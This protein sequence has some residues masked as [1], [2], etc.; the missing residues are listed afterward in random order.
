MGFLKDQGVSRR[1]FLKIPTPGDFLVPFAS[2]QKELAAAAAK[3]LFGFLGGCSACGRATFQRRKVAKVLRA[4]GPGPKGVALFRRQS[5][6]ARKPLERCLNSITAA[7]LNEPGHL[8]L[9]DDLRLSGSTYT[10]GSGRRAATRCASLRKMRNAPAG[11]LCRSGTP[12]TPGGN[13]LFVAHF[14]TN[15][16]NYG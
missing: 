13:P 9:Q 5:R 8:L 3:P 2:P 10:V 1:S 14:H 4:C 7:L 12:S 6:P 16:G 11:C 15:T